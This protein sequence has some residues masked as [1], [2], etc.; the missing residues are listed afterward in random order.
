ME[1]LKYMIKKILASESW[2]YQQLK[3]FYYR[4][5]AAWR[6]IYITHLDDILRQYAERRK[7]NVFFIN[8]GANDGIV[9]DPIAKYV[10]MYRWEGLMVEPVSYLFEQLKQNYSTYPIIFENSA[11]AAQSG[12]QK[13]YYLR[14]SER[15][16][17]YHQRI[18]SLNKHFLL[19]HGAEIPHLEEYLIEE[20]INCL[21]FDDLKKKYNISQVQLL[22]IDTEGQD[23][24]ILQSIDLK[25]LKTEIVIFEHIG[26]SFNTYKRVLL[27]LKR[28]EFRAYRVGRDTIGVQHALN[29]I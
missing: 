26:M 27:S 19:V 28:Q 15:L 16:P 25:A 20:E 23:A 2:L 6:P 4:L 11:V 1:F 3:K 24:E 13:F 8:I 29:L 17:D 5:G 21:S 18:G 22:L 9:E 12:K 7:S 14:A 10:K